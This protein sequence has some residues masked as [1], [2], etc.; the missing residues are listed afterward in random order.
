MHPRKQY[1]AAPELLR[2]IALVYGTGAAGVGCVVSAPVPAGDAHEPAGAPLLNE[3]AA[4]RATLALA[5]AR[6]VPELQA[7]LTRAAGDWAQA[8]E[9]ST[10]APPPPTASRPFMPPC[11]TCAP[12]SNP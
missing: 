5:D 10:P 12:C 3:I 2:P 8:H 6:G 7:L 4:T 11:S 1:E 9:P